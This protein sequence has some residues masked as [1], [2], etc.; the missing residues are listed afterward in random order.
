MNIQGFKLGEKPKT[1]MKQNMFQSKV[2][3]SRTI[4]IKKNANENNIY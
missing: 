1:K 4:N 2:G 3:E